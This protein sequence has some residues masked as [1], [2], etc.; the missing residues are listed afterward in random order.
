MGAQCDNR[1]KGFQAS[2][3][4]G[5]YQKILP[6]FKLRPIIAEPIQNP[7]SNIQNPKSGDQ[8]VFVGSAEHQSGD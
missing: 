4:K 8:R 6:N 5:N 2:L 7:K 1:K 3:F